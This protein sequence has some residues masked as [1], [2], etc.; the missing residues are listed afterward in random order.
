MPCADLNSLSST[1]DLLCLDFPSVSSKRKMKRSSHNKRQRLTPMSLMD[2]LSLPAE[3][4]P[5]TAALEESLSTSLNEEKDAFFEMLES[6]VGSQQ[7]K[8]CSV[9]FAFKDIMTHRMSFKSR[10]SLARDLGEVT[11]VLSRMTTSA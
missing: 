7:F 9:D 8:P 6:H 11:H 5:A 10:N 1:K 4:N 2:A 3:E